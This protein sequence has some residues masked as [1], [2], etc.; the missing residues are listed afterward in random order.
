MATFTYQ[1]GDITNEEIYFWKFL[2][3]RLSRRA[4]NFQLLIIK[5]QL[6]DL[7]WCNYEL[8]KLILKTRLD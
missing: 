4:A 7:I 8:F 5:V 3:V 6:S 2:Y 1:L